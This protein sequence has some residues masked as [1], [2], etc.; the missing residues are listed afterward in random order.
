MNWTPSLVVLPCL[1]PSVY[2][3]LKGELQTSLR[4]WLIT[5]SRLVRQLDAFLLPMLFSMTFLG[6]QAVE[7]VLHISLFLYVLCLFYVLGCDW[8]CLAADRHIRNELNWTTET[9]LLL[10]SKI[11]SSVGWLAIIYCYYGIFG[12]NAIIF[13]NLCAVITVAKVWWSFAVQE[14]WSLW[15][16]IISVSMVILL[17]EEYYLHVLQRR[18]I[19][20]SI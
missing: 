14:F 6:P 3:C 12:Q 17:R 19:V 1:I 13:M 16:N 2:A 11:T 18:K 10:Y 15:D 5:I 20:I 4:L 8:P 7:I 9:P